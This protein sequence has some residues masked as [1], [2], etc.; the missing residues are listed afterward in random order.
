VGKQYNVTV[1]D[2]QPIDPPI[3]GG[4]IRLLGLYHNL[5]ED[6]PTTYVGTYDWEGEKY[7]DHYLSHTLREIDVPLSKEHFNEVKKLQ[8]RVNVKTIIDVTFPEFAHLSQDYIR[9]AAEWVLKSDIVIFS[10]PWIYPLVKDQLNKDKQIIVYDSQNVEGYLRYNL[11]GEGETET[12]IVREVVKIEYELCHLSDIVLACSHEDSEL[13]NKLY[14]IPFEKIKVVPNGVFT[15]KIK[16]VDSRQKEVIKQEL[17]LPQ[18]MTAIFVASNYPPNVEAANYILNVLAPNLPDV[19]FLIAG[20]VGETVKTNQQNVIVTGKL[21]EDEKVQYLSAS[22]IAI[23]PMFSG[24]GTNIKMFDF[25]AAGLPIIS[26]PAGARGIEDTTFRSIKICDPDN[27]AANVTLILNDVK[28]IKLMSLAS[29]QLGEE[30]YSFERISKAFGTMLYRYRSKLLA[31]KP[32]F[33]IIVPSYNRHDQ[34]DRLMDALSLQNYKDFEVII[35][36]QSDSAWIN[37]HDTIDILYIHTDIKGATKARN[38][39]SLYARGKVLAFTDDDCVPEKN[40]L[41]EAH[42]IFTDNDIIGIE[43]L[44]KSDKLNDPNYRPV[45]NKGFEGIGFMTAN[46]FLKAEI[47]NR[48]NGFDGRFDNPHFREDTDLGWRAVKYGKIPFSD[49][50]QVFHPPHLR[51]IERE[52][53]KERNKFFEKDALLLKKHPVNYTKLFLLENHW[54]NTQGFWENLLTGAQKYNVDISQYKIYNYYQKY[55]HVEDPIIKMFKGITYENKGFFPQSTLAVSSRTRQEAVK[56]LNKVKDK[57]SDQPDD[58]KSYFDTSTERY[59]FTLQLVLGHKEKE[60]KK[61]LELGCS[62]GHLGMALDTMGLDVYGIDLNTEY[63]YKYPKSLIERLHIKQCNF[64]KEKIPYNDNTFDCVIFTEVLEHI[65][66]VSPAKVLA[67]IK[68]LL[69]PGGIM[70][71]STPNVSN[72]GNVFALMRGENIFWDP[73]IF[74]GSTDRHNR[75]YT[76]REVFSLLQDAGFH[77]IKIGYLNTPSN[78]N[79]KTA[80]ITMKFLTQIENKPADNPFFMNTIF[81][82]AEKG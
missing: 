37:K 49:K 74:Y 27:F 15:E 9:A 36:D 69:S 24:S 68:R 51:T 45:T 43:G 16:P 81:I 13:F 7:R 56:L 29:R 33:S 34:L 22:D 59:T 8:D 18:K 14:K 30:K 6:L 50:V 54:Q 52:S 47:F 55:M 66:I 28:L 73:Q 58:V 41:K 72:I 31:P 11:L 21:T 25:M 71:L 75:E 4:R 17:D 57:I 5:G 32:F 35:V 38:T 1:L 44:V 26:T 42:R 64:E 46:L 3:G 40:W 10:H 62:P 76:P 20:G 77:N 2:M 82:K 48:I 65:A 23:N 60:I 19:S 79:T 53:H 70:I 78:W 12:D 80:G 67:E 39:A 63:L 61:V